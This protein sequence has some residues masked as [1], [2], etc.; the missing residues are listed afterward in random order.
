[1]NRRGFFLVGLGGLAAAA[2]APVND[3]EAQPYGRGPDGWGPP[4]HRRRRR[5]R[6][7]IE[8]VR[9]PAR[10]YYGRPFWRYVRREVCR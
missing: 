8:T 6:C 7:W 3:A 1:M 2:L 5:R 9:V 10:D 4:G